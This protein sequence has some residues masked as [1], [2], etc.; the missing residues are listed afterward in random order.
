MAEPGDSWSDLA[1][2]DAS[3]LYAGTWETDMWI[4]FYFWSGDVSANTLQVRWQSSTNSYVWGYVLTPPGAGSWS[5]LNAGFANWD[6]WDIDP[7]GS[8]DQYLADLSSIDWIGI[9]VTR[10][11]TDEQVFGLDNFNLAIP[12]PEEW[13]LLTAALA[14]TVLSV[15]RRKKKRRLKELLSGSPPRNVRSPHS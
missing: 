10:S 15:G 11:G 3:G 1:K 12:E 7:G 6:D 2:T 9:Y 5:T 8:E 4:A 13:F 14:T